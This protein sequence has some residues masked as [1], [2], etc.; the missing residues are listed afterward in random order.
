M[1]ASLLYTDYYQVNKVGLQMISEL[2]VNNL[3]PV[4][5]PVHVPGAQLRPL[6]RGQDAALDRAVYHCQNKLRTDPDELIK[7]LK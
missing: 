7:A 5:K 1:M 6:V 4:V 3:M 2:A